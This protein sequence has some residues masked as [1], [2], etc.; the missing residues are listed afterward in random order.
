M[1]KTKGNRKLKVA[2]VGIKL[3]I[4]FADKKDEEDKMV[5]SSGEMGC[6]VSQ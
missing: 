2:H 5:K 4:E 1:T 6:P 3:W